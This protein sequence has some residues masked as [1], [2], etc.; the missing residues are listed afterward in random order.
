MCV[1]SCRRCWTDIALKMRRGSEQEPRR[2]TETRGSSADS[3]SVNTH[4]H[5]CTEAFIHF[6]LYRLSVWSLYWITRNSS[7]KCLYPFSIPFVVVW[8]AAVLLLTARCVLKKGSHCFHI[9]SVEGLTRKHVIGFVSSIVANK[10]HQND[11]DM[12]CF[13][14]FLFPDLFWGKH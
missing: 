14:F 2:T 3:E 8:I 1:R 4:P 6:L 11:Q 12:K 10:I 13:C 9:C 7:G 5:H